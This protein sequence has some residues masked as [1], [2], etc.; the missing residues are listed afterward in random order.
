MKR[1]R[2]KATHCTQSMKRKLTFAVRTFLDH[3]QENCIPDNMG[4]EEVIWT[5]E[6]S[7][8]FTANENYSVVCLCAYYVSG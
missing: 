7:S 8:Q 6:P 5:D 1:A 3:P 4:K 2:L